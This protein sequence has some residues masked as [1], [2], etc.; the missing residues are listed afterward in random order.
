MSRI[1]LENERFFCEHIADIDE[2]R[3]LI[4]SFTATNEHGEGL[5]RYLWYDAIS[6][7]LNDMMKTY[8]VRDKKTGELVGYFSLKA[9]MIPV[10]ER[11]LFNR[12]FD[13]VPGIELANFA[14]NG[15]YKES[16][17]DDEE[18]K[19]IGKMIF[20]C[21]IIPMVKNVAIYVGIKLLYIFA[22]PYDSLLNY[23]GKTL[24]FHRLPKREE[25]YV[26]KRI[27]PRYDQNCIFMYHILAD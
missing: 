7:E 9:G 10:N 12:T 26:H 5:V 25:R 18:T 1:V 14:V 4:W 13:S 2:V 15:S 16:H 24:D 11:G 20:L 22:L 27:K 23:Y 21:F 17:K 8:F 3:R 6:D 19:N